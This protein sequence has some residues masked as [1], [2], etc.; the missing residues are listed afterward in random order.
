SLTM[1]KTL[2]A[3]IEQFKKEQ[4]I[5][6][7]LYTTSSVRLMGEYS[8]KAVAILSDNI[9]QQEKVNGKR[10]QPIDSSDNTNDL[11]DK[12]ARRKHLLDDHCDTQDLF[13]DEQNQSS[14]AEPQQLVKRK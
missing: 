2:W 4:T 9:N 1:N 6:D 5:A 10:G 11:L 12:K 3:M 8:K 13:D 7:A 14:N